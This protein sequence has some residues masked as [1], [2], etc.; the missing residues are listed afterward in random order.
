MFFEF[1]QLCGDSF[2]NPPAA[3]SFSNITSFSAADPCMSRLSVT[4]MLLRFGSSASA[5][6]GTRHIRRANR[7]PVSPDLRLRSPLLQLL[8]RCQI[9]HVPVDRSPWCLTT[10]ELP[11]D[12]GSLAGKV[13]LRPSSRSSSRCRFS[14]RP[15]D[16]DM[17]A[18]SLES[19]GSI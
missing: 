12:T 1:P 4:T 10:G 11:T 8:P 5:T 3:F 18:N 15:F 19:T 9:N 16:P 2:T 7:L 17:C 6:S 14:L 13:P